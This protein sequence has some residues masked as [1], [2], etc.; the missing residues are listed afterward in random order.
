VSKGHA[1]A[2]GVTQGDRYC[3]ARNPRVFAKASS[4]ARRRQVVCALK[5]QCFAGCSVDDDSIDGG[6]ATRAP[7]RWHARSFQRRAWSTHEPPRPS[8]RSGTCHPEIPDDLVE[9]LTATGRIAEEFGPHGGGE[10]CLDAVLR[11]RNRYRRK[12]PGT[13]SARCG[14]WKSGPRASL[15]LPHRWTDFQTQFSAT[16]GGSRLGSGLE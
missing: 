8:L 3:I 4:F 15:N 16:A 1:K 14:R 11:R 2:S 12:W 13:Q 5:G 9:S 7:P 6:R 10:N